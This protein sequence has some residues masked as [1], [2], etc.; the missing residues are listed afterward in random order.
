[1]SSPPEGAD[2]GGDPR[3]GE[4]ICPGGAPS[5]GPPQHRS[6]PGPS[7]ADDTDANSNGSSGNESNGHE[8][9]GASQRSSHSSSSGNGKD[10]ALLETTESSKS[11]N[12]QSPSP[13]SS[14]VAYSLLSA[15]SE[16][17]NPSTSGCSSEQSARAR[18]QKELMTAL[19]ELKLRLPPERRGKGRSGTLATLQYALACVK[20]VQANQEYYQQWSLEE[21]EPCAMDMSTYT[22]EELEHITSEY[23]LRNQDT[24]SVA[25]SF[26]TGR[27]VYISE[28]AGILLH[29]KQDVF[30]GARFSELLAPQDVG[31][32]YGST[33]PSRLPTWGLG[34]SAGSGFKDFTQEKS[35]F[36]RIRG[37][38]DR[39]PVPRYQP[40]RLTP[41]VTKIRVSE[42]APAQPCCLLIAER[43]HSGYE[44]PRIPPDKRI[45]TTRHTPSCLFQDVD[46]RAAPLLGYL[47]QDLLGAPVLLFLHPE[48]RPLMLAIHKKVLQLAGQPFDHSPI[49]FC[50]RNGEYVTMDSSW[51]GFV[52]P[53]SRKVAFV[54]G[55]HKV[56][57]APLNED[58]FTPPVPS[59]ALSLDPDIQELSEQIHRLLLQPVHSPSAVGLCGVGPVTS[60]GPLFSPGSSSDSN[61]GD[62]EGPGPP[63]P[64]TF[65]QIC[66]DVHLVK[67][68][69][70]QLFI[71]SRARP[72]L[73]RPRFPGPA[74]DTVKAKT[75]YCQSPDPE[76]EADPALV[77]APPAVA[78]EEAERKEAS[79]C[80]YQQINSLDSILRYLESCNIPGTIKRKCASSSSSSSCTASSASDEDKQRTG[81]VP[82]GTKK[83]IV[84][85]EDLPGLAPCPAPS[86]T[87]APDPAPDAYRPVGLTKA[88]LSLHTQKEEQAFLSRF[89]DLGRLRGL[90]GSSM[91]PSAPGERGC[92]HG[93]TPPSRRYHCRS[94]AKRS[95]HHQIPRVEAPCYVSHPSSVPPSAPWPPPPAATPFPA[96]VQPYPLP[97]FSPRDGPQP[98]S[99]A[100]TSVSPA[101]FPAPLVTPV[102]ALVLPNY[103]FPTPS[104]YPY[105]VPQ[106]PAEGPPTPVSHSPSPSLPPPAPSP[107]HR[108]DSPLFN[109][110]CSSPLQL[111]LLQLEESLRVE[112]GAAAG[113][114]GS[115]AGPL[116]PSEETAEP[117]AR[118]VEATESSNQD[119][120]SGSSD[121][122]ELLLQ[123]D[124]RSGTGSAASGSL[125]SGLGSGS[126]SGSHEGGSTSASITRSSQ[127]SH[128][129][130]Y[131][132]SIDSSEAEAGAAQAKAEPGDQ[133]IKYVLQDPIWLLMANADQRVMMTYQVPSRDMASVLKQDRERLRAMQK[134][135]PRFS[136][137]QRRELGAVH[138]WVR[139]GQLPRVLDVMACVDCASSTQN[140]GHPEDPL[141][142]GLDGLGL[143]PMEEGGGEGGGGSCEDEGRDEAQAQA[144]AGVSS[145]Q[146]L[147]MEEEEQGGSSSSPALPATENGTS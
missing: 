55:R 19:R 74:I 122:L 84:M 5:P 63:A 135:Q 116:P 11:T 59:P 39:D 133:V 31:V 145:S 65:Q 3:P 34:A 69:G 20:Q 139:K 79:S 61:G 43:I 76:L 6:C 98:L 49:R 100:P 26:L 78:P 141:F 64:V 40:F 106:T 50:A 142:S 127:S 70:Q 97:I 147:A 12:S 21:G 8:S 119:A 24:F 57:T 109:S 104:S 66:K 146:D 71:E 96:V 120:L 51:A 107:P 113:G 47:P 130:K 44:A 58:V 41:Y 56:R 17:D 52:H 28:Q 85:M 92:H 114:P 95:R 67:H 143:E 13:P 75:L 32:F 112:G 7:L 9:R 42:G 15:S 10:S 102:V 101:A 144:G 73:P 108:P 16:Q 4:S 25:V 103:L 35:V 105:G 123:E 121:L 37:G 23:T 80:S 83:D 110:R 72:P 91:A 94:K 125:G 54:L 124:S 45:F 128:T 81:P 82:V 99:P 48:D 132:G 126:G 93:R 115:N 131:F 118:L 88:L 60:P 33:A 53:W 22:L 140:L 38:P 87:V 36:C 89:R 46:E 138:S 62:A 14:S 29:C 1:M 136:E 68:Q 129:S 18:T 77:Q 2:G 86:P 117:E 27:I 111:N 137:D 30:R 134:Q 90:N